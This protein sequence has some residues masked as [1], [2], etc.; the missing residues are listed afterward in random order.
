MTELARLAPAPGR[1]THLSAGRWNDE[2]MASHFLRL[3]GG[4][5]FD[6]NSLPFKLVVKALTRGTGEDSK[7]NPKYWS[8]DIVTVFKLVLGWNPDTKTFSKRQEVAA[9]KIVLPSFL[10][11]DSPLRRPAENLGNLGPDEQNIAGGGSGFEGQ[12]KTKSKAVKP[13]RPL[14]L[15]ESD[16]DYAGA[17]VGRGARAEAVGGLERAGC[18]GGKR[19]MPQQ[20]AKGGHG[21]AAGGRSEE[22]DIWEELAQ[23]VNRM[24]Q[25]DAKLAGESVSQVVYSLCHSVEELKLVRDR[26]LADAK[27]RNDVLLEENALG[28]LHVAKKF[29]ATVKCLFSLSDTELLQ[30]WSMMRLRLSSDDYAWMQ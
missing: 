24:D 26:M 29:I 23:V 27:E 21:G 13:A 20:G 7:G 11:E 17:P 16:D 1:E 6:K 15:D 2:A 10:A 28:A 22:P 25:L 14:P 19:A 3:L 8:V 30:Y 12:S 9:L 4:E 5:P 18:D